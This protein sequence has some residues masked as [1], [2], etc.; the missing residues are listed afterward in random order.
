MAEWRSRRRRGDVLL[1]VLVA[2]AVFVVGATLLLATARETLA[3]LDR[4]QRREAA[5]D[6]ARSVLARLEA[7]VINLQ[8]ARAG[9]VG[10]DD[11]AA[12]GDEVLSVEV[13]TRRSPWPG[14]ALVEVRVRDRDAARDGPS[15]CMLRQLVP[16]GADDASAVDGL[17]EDEA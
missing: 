4:A 2:L 9:R 6:L 11:E 12:R 17:E 13:R 3:S 10:D 15:L 8:D 5:T 14:L 16:L 7:G 1:E